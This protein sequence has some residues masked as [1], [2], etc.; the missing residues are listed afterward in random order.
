VALTQIL[1][2][3]SCAW[4]GVMALKSQASSIP[5]NDPPGAQSSQ[6]EQSFQ[7]KSRLISPQ[8]V[9]PSREDVDLHGQMH[10]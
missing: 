2:V 6:Q 5:I 10:V 4:L 8:Y 9:I 7:Q 3:F 1:H